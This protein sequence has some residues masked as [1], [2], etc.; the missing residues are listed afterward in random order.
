MHGKQKIHKLSQ[1]AN[2]KLEKIAATHFFKVNF[3]NI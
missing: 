3:P 2:N 1:K